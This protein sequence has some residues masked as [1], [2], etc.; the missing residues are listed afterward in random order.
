MGAKGSQGEPRG[1]DTDDGECIRA[2]NK[3][4]KRGND[5][6]IAK[7]IKLDI[8][9]RVAQWGKGPRSRKKT[10]TPSCMSHLIRRGENETTTPE[11]H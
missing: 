8:G 6:V 4:K 5:G 9:D 1:V 10:E 2:E 7:R 11:P 3:G